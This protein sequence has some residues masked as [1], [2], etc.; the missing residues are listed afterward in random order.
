MGGWGEET[1]SFI[2]PLL[3]FPI[4]LLIL[5]LW[6]CSEPI[7]WETLWQRTRIQIQWGVRDVI[8]P[9][10]SGL[11]R[12]LCPPGR[13]D[14]EPDLWSR[15]RCLPGGGCLPGTGPGPGPWLGPSYFWTGPGMQLVFL[16]W[17]LQNQRA[18]LYQDKLPL[19]PVITVQAMA[20]ALAGDMQGQ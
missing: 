10:V 6:F 20:R 17:P 16:L 8:R 19:R 1:Q 11:Q 5:S 2:A 12:H 3:I 18:L 9:A 15:A 7:R 13:D 4:A 14:L